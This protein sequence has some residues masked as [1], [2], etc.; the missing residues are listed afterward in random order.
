M[1]RMILNMMRIMIEL[2]LL[3][4]IPLPQVLVQVLVQVLIRG[5]IPLWNQHCQLFHL[6]DVIFTNDSII[7]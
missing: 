2:K 4:T 1:M 6:E 3:W 7:K 5:I